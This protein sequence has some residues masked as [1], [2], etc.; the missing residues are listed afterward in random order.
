METKLRKEELQSLCRR[1]VAE[2]A[3]Q[4]REISELKAALK[5]ADRTI[6]GHNGSRF[7]SIPLP[8]RLFQE[9]RDGFEQIC[10]DNMEGYG[11]GFSLV[12]DADDYSRRNPLPPEYSRYLVK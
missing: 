4:S 7:V 10:C 9:Y 1:Q 5:A 2:M 12:F 6:C 3:D 11:T 8:D